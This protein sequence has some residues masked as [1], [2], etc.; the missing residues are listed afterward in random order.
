LP[1]VARIASGALGTV[2]ISRSFGAAVASVAELVVA[3]LPGSGV[4]P[5]TVPVMTTSWNAPARE[6]GSALTRTT[7]VVVLPAGARSIVKLSP[8]VG[9]GEKVLTVQSAV[10]Q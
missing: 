8:V 9:Y 2:S 4:S 7:T 1:A 5:S 6:F 10:W 3:L